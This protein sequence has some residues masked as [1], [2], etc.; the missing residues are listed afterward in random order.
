MVLSV[1]YTSGSSVLLHFSGRLRLWVYTFQSPIHRDPRF[2]IQVPRR[3]AGARRFQSPIHR[4]PRFYRHTPPVRSVCYSFQSPIHRD[5]RFY[6]HN[7]SSLPTPFLPFSPLYIGILGSTAWL[8]TIPRR[9]L[10]LSVPYTSGSSVLQ[11]LAENPTLMKKIFQSPI[12]R[13]PRFYRGIGATNHAAT[14]LSVPYTSGSSV[15][16]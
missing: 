12:H 16:P 3:P 4:D 6:R 9:N 2:Y 10:S 13:D 15:L 8:T 1:P 11:E 14:V 7:H 5:P